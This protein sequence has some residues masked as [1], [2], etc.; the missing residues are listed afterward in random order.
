M[1]IPFGYLAL[2]IA[3]LGAVASAWLVC[4]AERRLP[5]PTWRATGYRYLHTGHDQSLAK[6]AT[7]RASAAVTQRRVIASIRSRPLASARPVKA[8]AVAT[9]PTPKRLPS[10][11]VVSIDAR[12]RA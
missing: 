4:R 5:D 1:A 7:K 10:K 2:I 9:T 6:E 12:K 11:N 8:Q 3:G